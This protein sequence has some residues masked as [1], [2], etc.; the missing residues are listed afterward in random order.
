MSPQQIAELQSLQTNLKDLPDYFDT[1]DIIDVYESLLPYWE[2]TEPHLFGQELD[3]ILDLE[4]T[5]FRM[6]DIN[7]FFNGSYSQTQTHRANGKNPKA[8]ELAR[9]I[10][11]SGWNAK[12]PPPAI[13]CNGPDQ[14]LITGNTR[15]HI[16]LDNGVRRCVV[17][18]W[19]PISENP[20]KA[21]IMASYIRAGQYMQPPKIDTSGA[22]S[23]KYDIVK[24][25]TQLAE[26]GTIE[27]SQSSLFVECE[28]LTGRSGFQPVTK[29]WIVQQ[30][31]NK[32]HPGHEIHAWTAASCRE[33][34][35]KE[36][37]YQDGWVEKEKATVVH[38][39]ASSSS[40][41]KVFGSALRL[42][43]Q[44]VNVRIVVHTSTLESEGNFEKTWADRIKL[45]LSIID[46]LMSESCRISGGNINEMRKRINPAFRFM[47]VLGELHDMNQPVHYNR[48]TSELYQKDNG[49]SFPLV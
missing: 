42:I 33:K 47:P 30:A 13:I 21:D 34:C 18:T 36:W 39:Y 10:K 23:Q 48:K 17:S 15:F 44:D 45:Y 14:R 29:S 38:L 3:P 5:G 20:S 24:S 35:Q 9:T 7:T 37:K 28:R 19:K 26:M 43:D 8:D 27:S 6:V 22:S 32:F 46:N 11:S 1:D 41:D 12:F 25:L 2:R 4:F 40:P 49:Y 31:Y 16:L